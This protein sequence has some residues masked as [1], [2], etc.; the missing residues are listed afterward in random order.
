MK[1]IVIAINLVSLVLLFLVTG[2]FM[3]SNGVL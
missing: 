2:K 3:V 1:K